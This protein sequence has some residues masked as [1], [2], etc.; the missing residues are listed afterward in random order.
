MRDK[1]VSEEVAKKNVQNLIDDTWKKMNKDRFNNNTIT[2]INNCA[3]PKHFV[4][5]GMNLARNSQCTYLHGN[6]H[7]DP[8]STA[9]NRIHSLI[10]E[11]ISCTTLSQQDRSIFN[12]YRDMLT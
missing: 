3:F 12:H 8:N 1:G 7:G 2:S 6:G 4:E 9:K 11:P 5:T 10:I